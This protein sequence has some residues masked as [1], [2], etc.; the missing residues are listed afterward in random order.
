MAFRKGK[1]SGRSIS[2]NNLQYHFGPLKKIKCYIS[3]QKQNTWVFFKCPHVPMPL[4]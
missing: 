3:T 4:K 2:S 1:K